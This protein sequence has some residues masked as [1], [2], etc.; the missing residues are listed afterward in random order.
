MI[1]G[2]LVYMLHPV[3]FVLLLHLLWKKEVWIQ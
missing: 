3:L 2:L 1:R